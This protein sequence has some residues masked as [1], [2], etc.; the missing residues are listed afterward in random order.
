MRLKIIHPMPLAQRYGQVLETD[1][2]VMMT[3]F[4][5]SESGK[6][7]HDTSLIILMVALFGLAVTVIA[8]NTKSVKF[9]INGSNDTP[10]QVCSVSVCQC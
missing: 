1:V 10:R 7:K 4:W 6:T 9:S 5:Q 8:C 3:Y 2:Y